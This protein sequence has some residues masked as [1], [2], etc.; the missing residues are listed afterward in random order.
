[1]TLEEEVTENWRGLRRLQHLV[2]SRM[3]EGR[4]RM[5]RNLI[6]IIIVENRKTE[7]GAA[8]VWIMYLQNSYV[9]APTLYVIVFRDGALG[10]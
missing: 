4:S 6:I 10:R 2:E 3:T 9:E 8:V 5:F 1:M 7:E